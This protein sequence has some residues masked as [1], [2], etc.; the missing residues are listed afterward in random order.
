M[1]AVL[2]VEKVDSVKGGAAP[3]E[4]VYNEGIRLSFYKKTHSICDSVKR[5]WKCKSSPWDN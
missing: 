5:F 4:E 3:G 2:G 1:A